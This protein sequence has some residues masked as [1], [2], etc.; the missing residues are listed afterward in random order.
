[1][2]VLD[3]GS[4]META[5]ATAAAA[6]KSPDAERRWSSAN[7]DECGDDDSGNELVEAFD[8]PAED[9]E[10]AVEYKWSLVSPPPA[11]FLEL[12]TQLKYRMLEGNG[13]ALY[14][15]GYEDD[16]TARGVPEH[17]LDASLDTLRQMAREVDAEATE[18]QRGRGRD[19]LVAQMLV[20]AKP[21]STEEFTDLRVCVSGNVDAGKS[22]LLGVL[23]GAGRLD[24]GRGLA[25]AQVLTHKHELES[26]RT[27]AIST[28][29]IGFDAAGR[30][31]NYSDATAAASVRQLSWSDIVERSAKLITFSDLAGHERYLKTTMFGLTAHAPDYC[32][33]VVALNQGVLRMTKEHLAIA[34]ALKVPVF[35]A[36][37]KTDLT[38]AN[39]RERTVQ[40]LSKLLK[41]PGARKLPAMVRSFE[42]AASCA[43]NM[44]NDRAVPMFPV[45]NVTGEGLDRLRSFLNL[46]PPRHDWSARSDG[47]AEFS[48]D[49]H[50]SVTG[51]G[52]VV[53]G[54]CLRGSVS[55]GQSV[56]LGPDGNGH[57]MRCAVKSI[58]YKKVPVRRV[59]AGQTGSC[60]LKRVRRE[61]VRKGMVMLSADGREPP[62][63]VREFDAEIMLMYHSTS[64]RC[65]Y[66]PVLHC[67]TVRQAAQVTSTEREVIRTGER[68]R[69]R[70]RFLYRP[71]WLNEGDRFCFREGR[72]KGI[73]KVARVVETVVKEVVHHH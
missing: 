68:A 4:A 18:M 16:G 35:V 67:G 22:S 39:V 6:A 13:E 31:V 51:V 61:R 25:R 63:C 70:L 34:L 73:G 19:G 10:G 62:S 44:A 50:F 37:T 45:S 54:M 40:H 32:M 26:G 29:L 23:C 72:T 38:P 3:T 41:S 11:R 27:S 1:M 65:G 33:I 20:R 59:V 56:Y 52:T 17:A 69:V 71:E 57:F 21:R 15:L 53:S 12:V 49:D 30:V 48:V 8:L 24:N 5:A 60:A 2:S 43:Q 66:Q 28:Q 7:L 14:Q 42:E 58:H 64:V 46:L 47:G 36:L 9:D 55:V